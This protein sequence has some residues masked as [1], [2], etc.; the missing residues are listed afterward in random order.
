[1][2]WFFPHSFAPQNFAGTNH[3]N[4]M[5]CFILCHP[6]SSSP[7]TLIG[8]SKRIQSVNFFSKCTNSTFVTTS[9][10]SHVGSHT[11]S[12][13]Q[14]TTIQQPTSMN[15]CPSTQHMILW[16]LHLHLALQECNQTF[17]LRS[18]CLDCSLCQTCAGFGV[19]LSRL[20]RHRKSLGGTD[21]LGHADTCAQNWFIAVANFHSIKVGKVGKESSQDCTNHTS[22]LVTQRF[23][24][25]I[26]GPDIDHQEYA[27]VVRHGK[28]ANLNCRKGSRCPFIWCW[29]ML[30]VPSKFNFYAKCTPSTKWQ[31]GHPLQLSLCSTCFFLHLWVEVLDPEFHILV[32][33][34]PTLASS[35][36]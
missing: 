10:H 8:L 2:L 15:H 20:R 6:T 21:R 26:L 14:M 3:H 32:V 31:M 33:Q 23:D 13:S 9:P 35:V 7:L 24:T 1:M 16:N 22:I 29:P 28:E 30:V 12:W 19:H 4:V 27:H 34:L 18:D 17:S 36:Q 11:I 25:N 5:V